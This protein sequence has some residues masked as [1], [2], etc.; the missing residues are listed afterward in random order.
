MALAMVLYVA[1]LPV[2]WPLVRGTASA[3][4]KVALALLARHYGSEASCAGD[5]AG[6]PLRWRLLLVAGLTAL[7]GWLA[8]RRRDGFDHGIFVGMAAAA[9]L[10]VL[11]Q[12]IL[13]WR[14][15]RSSTVPSHDA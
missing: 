13:R 7:V 14:R 6:I 15:R 4:F 11:V 2:A 9:V 8:W 10:F 1:V 3:P 5:D 12:G